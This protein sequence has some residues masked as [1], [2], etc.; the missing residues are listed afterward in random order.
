MAGIYYFDCN[1]MSWTEVNMGLSIDSIEIRI[2]IRLRVEEI[3]GIIDMYHWA[4]GNEWFEHSVSETVCCELMQAKMSD[5]YERIYPLIHMSFCESTHQT[6]AKAGWVI[7]K[8]LDELL[9]LV[10]R[11][12]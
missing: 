4:L 10:K 2:P 3:H 12:T 8:S 6:R 7:M 11:K 1:P 9:E 5:L